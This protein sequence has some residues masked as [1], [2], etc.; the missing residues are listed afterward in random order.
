MT[1]AKHSRPSAIRKPPIRYCFI[2]RE[3]LRSTAERRAGLC[4]YHLTTL[5]K[6]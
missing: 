1:T 6:Q 3:P 2:D 5:R 4:A